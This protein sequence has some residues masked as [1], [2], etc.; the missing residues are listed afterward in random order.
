MTI[1]DRIRNKR[2][3]LGWSQTDLAE[4]AHYGDKTRISKIENSGDDISMKQIKKIADALGVSTAY[5]MGWEKTMS[6]VSEQLSEQLKPLSEALEVFSYE[7]NNSDLKKAI[8]IW[9]EIE[10][11]PQDKKDNLIKYLQFLKSD[12]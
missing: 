10:V 7:I 11:L 3:E 4:R 2:I 12:L 6:A 9:K 8:E 1:A 5:L